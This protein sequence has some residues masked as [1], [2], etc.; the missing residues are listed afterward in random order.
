MSLCLS[1]LCGTVCVYPSSLLY[2]HLCHLSRNSSF[3]SIHWP[4]REKNIPS[5]NTGD[6]SVSPTPVDAR[7]M[8]FTTKEGLSDNDRQFNRLCFSPQ[9]CKRVLNE[10]N[11]H[12]YLRYR[13]H[14]P[15]TD[16]NTFNA[17]A[18]LI[19]RYTIHRIMI[20]IELIYH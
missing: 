20:S 4:S 19:F 1:L 11:S 2:L 18:L 5:I 15:T 6:A 16:I 9:L 7:E 3:F 14:D 17:T 13:K 12:C 10:S 8:S